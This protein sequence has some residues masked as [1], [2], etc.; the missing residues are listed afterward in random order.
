MSKSIFKFKPVEAIGATPKDVELEGEFPGGGGSGAKAIEIDLSK[1]IIS[2]GVFKGSSNPNL[3]YMQCILT[4]EKYEE[5]ISDTEKTATII[6]K[7]WFTDP[8]MV[9]Y[10][11][12]EWS[13]TEKNNLLNSYEQYVVSALR[14][15]FHQL[16]TPQL[17]VDMEVYSNLGTSVFDVMGDS[18]A[19][20]ILRVRRHVLI[21]EPAPGQPK[22][23]A[24]AILGINI[25]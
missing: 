16:P 13:E 17:P 2:V 7:G 3:A 12:D 10:G 24:I 20:N 1:D 11:E 5:I 4:Q 14:Y 18:P 21:T 25:A 22:V 19:E 8:A 9:D 15:D 23:A 6:S